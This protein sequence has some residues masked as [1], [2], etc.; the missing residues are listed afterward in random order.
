M[1]THRIDL[2]RFV[3]KDPDMWQDESDTEEKN[4]ERIRL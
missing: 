3:Q 1:Y 4:V 2:I